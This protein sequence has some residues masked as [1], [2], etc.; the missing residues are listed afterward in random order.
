MTCY[1]YYVAPKAYARPMIVLIRILASSLPLFILPALAAG[2]A[3]PTGITSVGAGNTV[4][5]L[6]YGT[7]EGHLLGP[8][9]TT[10]RLSVTTSSGRS[11]PGRRPTTFFVSTRRTSLWSPAVAVTPVERATNCEAE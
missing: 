4:A 8:R 10:L 9:A 1:S 7:L 3:Q 2:S 11:A 6:T 5:K